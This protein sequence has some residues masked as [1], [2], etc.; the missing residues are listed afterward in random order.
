[1][2]FGLTTETSF[3]GWSP[4]CGQPGLLCSWSPAAVGRAR[5]AAMG[6][7]FPRSWVEGTKLHRLMAGVCL[8]YLWAGSSP[9]FLHLQVLQFNWS[10]LAAVP[11]TLHISCNGEVSFFSSYSDDR[12]P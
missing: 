1:M 9:A 11:R 7:T 12:G 2:H 4:S 10:Q 6:Q 3:P 5:G 8:G